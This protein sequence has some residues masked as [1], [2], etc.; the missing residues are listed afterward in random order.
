MAFSSILIHMVSTA[1]KPCKS[2][3]PGQKDDANRLGQLSEPEPRIESGL[4]KLSLESQ[5]LIFGKLAP[6][7][8]IRKFKP[9]A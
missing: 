3:L 2:L 7:R 4:L 1:L 8:D 6:S 5:R 9:S